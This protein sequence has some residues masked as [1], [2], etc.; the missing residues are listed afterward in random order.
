MKVFALK[1]AQDIHMQVK[2][3]AAQNGQSMLDWIVE[4]LKEKLEKVGG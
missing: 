2:I 1:L 3:A 4:A